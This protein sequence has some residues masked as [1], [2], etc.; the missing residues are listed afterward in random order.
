MPIVQDLWNNEK[1]RIE[2]GIFFNDDTFIE[3]ENGCLHGY[4]TGNRKK[5]SH[6]FTV[7]PDWKFE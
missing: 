4:S 1:I 6:L 3:I 5:V 7:N 2:Q